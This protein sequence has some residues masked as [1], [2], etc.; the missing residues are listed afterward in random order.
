MLPL[1]PSHSQAGKRRPLVHRLLKPRT[2][3]D[4]LL[5]RLN[6]SAVRPASA[7]VRPWGEV[8]SRR[9]A[10]K[11]IPTEGFACPNQ[12]CPYYGITDSPIHAA[13]W[14]WQAWSC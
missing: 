5:C 1:Q 12:Q 11:R 10:P 7:P 9:G 13:F 6:S 8:K 14:G 2:S 4:C 3:L